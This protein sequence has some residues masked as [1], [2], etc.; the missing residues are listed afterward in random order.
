[1][2][3]LRLGYDEYQKRNAAIVVLGPENAASFA[4]YWAQNDLPFVGLP[5]P[6]H[7]VLGLYGQEFR[8]FKLGRM[9]AQV[10]IDRSGMVRYAHYG[11]SMKDIP[12]NE[13][14]WRLLDGMDEK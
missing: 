13:E 6:E 5:D 9:P 7:R 3:Q 1:M 10:I 8:L 12:R 11:D 2:A 4:R 14:L